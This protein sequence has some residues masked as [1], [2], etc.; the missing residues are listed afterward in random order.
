SRT[1]KAPSSAASHC[2]KGRTRGRQNERLAEFADFSPTPPPYTRARA[3]ARAMRGF[4][5][6]VRKVRKGLRRP[7]IQLPTCRAPAGAL[8]EG[9]PCLG[10]PPPEFA[11]WRWRL[12]ASNTR[13]RHSLG[14]PSTSGDAAPILSPTLD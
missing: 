3:H 13:L 10:E 12:P 11:A 9:G 6:K 7:Q 2:R 14:S 5:T 8:L 1:A 4:W